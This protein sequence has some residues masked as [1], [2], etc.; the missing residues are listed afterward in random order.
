VLRSVS[1]RGGPILSAPPSSSTDRWGRC[2]N[3]AV[4]TA[5]I[6]IACLAYQKNQEA[7]SIS[8]QSVLLQAAAT[9][10]A[11]ASPSVPVRRGKVLEASEMGRS[12]RHGGG[13]E[14]GGGAGG[15][16]PAAAF[17]A[18]LLGCVVMALVCGAAAQG[19]RLPSDYKTLSGN[20]FSTASS[21]RARPVCTPLLLLCAFVRRGR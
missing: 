6:Y 12:R 18:P 1:L 2:L 5:A 9:A 17:A 19:P 7:V 13:R 21:T 4:P 8:F 10:T 15:V 11:T 14:R 20:T 3:A 16:A